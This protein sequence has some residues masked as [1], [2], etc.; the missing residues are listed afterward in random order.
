MRTCILLILVFLLFPFT[1]IIA[2]T[3]ASIEDTIFIPR[4]YY[5]GDEVELRIKLNIADSL[6]LTLPSS[7]PGSSWININSIEIIDNNKIP[8]LRII[9]TSFIPGTRSFPTL[10]LGEII[11]NSIKIHTS[12]L[13]DSTGKNFI[14]IAGQLLLPGTKLGLSIIVGALFMGPLFLIILLGPFKR[15]MILV[16]KN[17]I[18][19]SPVKRLNR[20]LKD[21]AVQ[22]TGISC[23][24]FYIRLSSAVR[25]YLS[26]RTDTDFITLTTSD[27]ELALIRVLGHRDFS[28]MLS[29]MMKLSDSIKFGNMTTGDEKKMSDIELIRDIS[30]FLELKIKRSDKSRSSV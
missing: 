14:G 30:K 5:V 7:L 24:R 23:R 25:E 22:K 20:I 9:F 26:K 12:S 19:R 4:E 1:S 28:S 10:F 3:G 15:K 29:D 16:M 21:L 27:M 8:E 17:G 13:I 2:D 11:L 6:S 18:G